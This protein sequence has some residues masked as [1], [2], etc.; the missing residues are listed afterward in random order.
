MSII[1][2]SEE[3]KAANCD[4]SVDESGRYAGTGTREFIV[5]FDNNDIPASRPYIARDTTYT[6]GG[7]SIPKMW[8][9]HPYEP[10]IFVNHKTVSMFNGPTAWKVT[11]HYKEIPDPLLEDYTVDWLFASVMEPI[12]KDR[13]G[14]A[15]VNSADESFDPPIQEE[16]NDL[17]LRI[18]RHEGEYNP[19]TAAEYKKAVNSDQ[20]L[21]F[22]PYTVKCSLFEGRR[23]RYAGLYYYQVNYEFIIRSDP[24][25][26][27]NISGWKR[28]ILDQG[29]RE[30]TGTDG[31][32]KPTYALILDDT[33]KPVNQ[34]VLLNGAGVKKTAAADPYYFTFETKPQKPFSLFNFNI[35]DPAFQ[36]II[37]V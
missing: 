33:S 18:T 8:E 28:R 11:V 3:I 1:D 13:N 31:E 36:A 37:P 30:K 26:D 12:D 15:L 7:V 14:A 5:I 10:Y 24:D 27:N 4:L 6:I 16:Y 21:W 25:A 35:T 19:L 34:P 22:D 9:A 2:I 29:F 20:F 17:V 32:G 23:I